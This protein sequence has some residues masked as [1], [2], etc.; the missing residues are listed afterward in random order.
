MIGS[1]NS[2]ATPFPMTPTQFTVLTRV[3]AG[4]AK[5]SPLKALSKTTYLVSSSNDWMSLRCLGWRPGCNLPLTFTN[6]PSF[7][8]ALSA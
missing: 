2:R 8:W 5:R 3:C 6:A 4:L 7:M 1:M